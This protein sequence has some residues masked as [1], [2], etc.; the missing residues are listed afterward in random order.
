MVPSWCKSSPVKAV[1]GRPV[2]SVAIH[3]ATG[4]CEAY[5]VRKRAARNQLRKRPIVAEADAVNPAEGST[6]ATVS[7]RSSGAA[8][9]HSPGHVS[10][11]APQ[12]PRRARHLLRCRRRGTGRQGRPE[13]S[14]TGGRA[15]LRPHSTGEGGEP[16]GSR[17]GRPRYPLEGRGEQA[18]VSVKGH[19][20]RPRTRRENVNAT[21]PNS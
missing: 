1:A 4:G 17:K 14:G 18:D 20:T 8:G 6:R 7:A 9:V 13:R 12:E 5:T 19:I 3:R 21:E 10:I 16:Q 11:G 15:V 2:A